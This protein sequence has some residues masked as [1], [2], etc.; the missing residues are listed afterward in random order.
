V[1]LTDRD[2]STDTVAGLGTYLYEPDGAVIRAGLVQQ[3]AALV[4]GWRIDPQLA[5]LSSDSASM[6]PL[7]KGY[8]IDAVM[9]YSVK[10]LRAELHR[11][12]VGI[13]EIKKRGVDVDP[14]R[15]RVE[16]KPSG[17]NSLTVILA[18]AGAHRLA[19]LAQPLAA[20][21]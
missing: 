4:E 10:R 12:E 2:P 20:R 9:P 11:R 8:R 16:L 19:V 13:V 15:L 21:A 17:P 5:Y 18:R 14:A 1:E 3:A 6:S 7:V